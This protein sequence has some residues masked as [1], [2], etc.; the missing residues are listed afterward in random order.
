MRDHCQNGAWQE[1]GNQMSTHSIQYRVQWGDTDAAG[2]AFY[3]NYFRWFDQAANEFL[4]VLVLP[5]EMVVGRQ[6]IMP[7]I[8]VGCRFQKPVR[9]GDLLTLETTTTEVRSRTFRLEHRAL[10]GEEI[11]G[12]GYEVRGWAHI[13]ASS[14]D[15]LELVVIPDEMRMRLL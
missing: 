14:N 2:I 6:V 8:E 3:P 4:R 9:Y 15:T 10:R 13:P 7:V 5:A 1:I 12:L 11:I